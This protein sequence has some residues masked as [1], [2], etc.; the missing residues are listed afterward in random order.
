M[1][2]YRVIV[3][4]DEIEPPPAPTRR[5]VPRSLREAEV[6]RVRRQMGELD[7]FERA[8]FWDAVVRL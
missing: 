8:D 3:L 7:P 6:A 2:A 5:T 1:K 4:G